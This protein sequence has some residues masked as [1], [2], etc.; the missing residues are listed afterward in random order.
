MLTEYINAAM[1]SAHYELLEGDEG[2]IGKT[3]VIQ[4]V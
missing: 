4:D 1:R 3:R 2:Y